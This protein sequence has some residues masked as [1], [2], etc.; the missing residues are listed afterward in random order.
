MGEDVDEQRPVGAQPD[1][2]RRSSSA[3]LR[4]CSNISTD[5]TRSS[6]AGAVSK[7]LT[8]R[9]RTSTLSSPR[10]AARLAM[11]SRW[12]AEFEIAVIRELGY[13]AA[14]HSVRLP[15]PQPSS[16]TSWPSRRSARSQVSRSIA[17]SACARLATPSGQYAEEYFRCGPSISSKSSVGTS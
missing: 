9:V 7:S 4:T 2:M 15:Q 1:A 13:R 3:W 5:T 10:S 11:W 6:E 8:S 16:S 17:S 14:I 12:V